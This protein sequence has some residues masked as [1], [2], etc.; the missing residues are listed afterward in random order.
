MKIAIAGLGRVGTEFMQEI[1][2]YKEKGIEIVAVAEVTDTPGKAK[3]REMG[4]QVLTIKEIVDMGESLDIIFDLT[5]NTHA[6]KELRDSLATAANKHTVIA[7]EN[8]AYL[9]WTLSTN[10]PL[11]DVHSHKGY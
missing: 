8:V 5:G 3:A 6:R 10:K 2:R 1:S 7:P 9:I 4:I 11:P